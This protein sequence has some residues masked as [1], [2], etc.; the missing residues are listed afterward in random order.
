M[1]AFL[2]SIFS[3]QEGGAARDGLPFWLFWLLLCVILLLLAL[4]FLRDKD[5]RQR[6]NRFFFGF[7][8]KITKIRLQSK[9]KK[10]N[11]NKIELLKE[12]GK[13]A[14]EEEI[15]PEQVESITKKIE[16][17]E[18]KKNLNQKELEKINSKIDRLKKEDSEYRQSQEAKIKKQD[19]ERKPLLEKM[20]EINGK[21]KKA[22]KE[23]NQAKKEVQKAE[24]ENKK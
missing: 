18:E 10:E 1:K 13:K 6:V 14:W 8:R 21:G 5:L 7:R 12:L 22:E 19:V 15:K 20:T 24:K 23:L 3:F 11:R 17:L 2:N 16:D 4:I 9:I